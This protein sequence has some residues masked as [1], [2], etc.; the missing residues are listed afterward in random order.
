MPGLRLLLLG[1]VASALLMA[2]ERDP[3]ADPRYGILYGDDHAF[4]FE[5]PN[6]W[7]LDVSSG[8]DQGL[9]AVLYLAD[10]S[11]RDSPVIAYPRAY[12]KREK[13]RTVEA[14]FQDVLANLRAEEPG[15]SATAAGTVLTAG[16]RTGFIYRF[17]GQAN[18]TV[19]A[20]AYFDEEKTVNYFVYS[21]RS[22]AEF[23]KHY[24]EFLALARSYSYMGS[25]PLENGRK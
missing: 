20:S 25:K 8:V 15:I 4:G 9:K 17:S 12:S 6:G 1:L 14:V 23:D 19:E 21:A 13:I 24:A 16:K 10:S 3:A 7:K 5:A 18:G 2:Q 11:W 22:K